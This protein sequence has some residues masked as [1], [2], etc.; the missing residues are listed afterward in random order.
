MPEKG[1]DLTKD[2]KLLT[3]EEVPYYLNKVKKTT[4]YIY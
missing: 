3:R 4:F 1:I 2:D